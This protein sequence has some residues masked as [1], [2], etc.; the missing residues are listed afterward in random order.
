[1][2]SMDLTYNF[3]L[4]L[5]EECVYE[6][7]KLFFIIPRIGLSTGNAFKS[8]LIMYSFMFIMILHESPIT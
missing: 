2:N 5:K 3:D 8:H 6:T 4:V 7:F 1:M